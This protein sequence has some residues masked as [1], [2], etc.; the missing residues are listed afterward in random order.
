MF[1]VRLRKIQSNH[2]N[3]RTDVVLGTCERLPEVGRDFY[4][5]SAAL[6]PYIEAMGGR[7]EIRTTEVQV[8]GERV[9]NTITFH[10]QNSQYEL[11]V[12]EEPTCSK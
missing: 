9:G 6:N 8:L 4:L 3:L 10:T 11:D 1:K 5:D 12:L 2:S 7:R